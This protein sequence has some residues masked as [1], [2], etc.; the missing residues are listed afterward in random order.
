M[1]QKE[2]VRKAVHD[3][4]KKILKTGEVTLGDSETFSNYGVDSLDQMNL[5]LEVEQALGMQL[6]DV[7]LETQN[8]IDL[9]HDF[10]T[11]KQS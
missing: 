8:S 2:A 3:G 10:I 6:G 9:L 4:L 11:Q 5:L 1:V 7:D